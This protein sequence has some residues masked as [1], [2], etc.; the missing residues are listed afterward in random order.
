MSFLTGI[1]KK[2]LNEDI[3]EEK[4]INLSYCKVPLT[5]ELKKRKLIEEKR[6]KYN[7]PKEKVYTLE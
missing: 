7:I 6:V 2:N 5:L 3:E 1:L 4:L